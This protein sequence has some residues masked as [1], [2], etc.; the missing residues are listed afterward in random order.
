MDHDKIVLEPNLERSHI[1]LQFGIDQ[2]DAAQAPQRW[3]FTVF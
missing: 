1:P 3:L 2:N